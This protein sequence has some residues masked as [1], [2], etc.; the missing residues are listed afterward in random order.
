MPY[1][2]R[3]I[4]GPPLLLRG[5][6]A[7]QRLFQVLMMALCAS[8]AYGLPAAAC[9]GK[10]IVLD[11]RTIDY[12]TK[13]YDALLTPLLAKPDAEIA[14]I[15]ITFAS[16]KTHPDIADLQNAAL[17]YVT[18]KIALYGYDTALIN[19]QEVMLP[20]SFAGKDELYRLVIAY[21]PKM[22]AP[23]SASEPPC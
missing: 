8:L 18:S 19:R 13:P 1:H 3:P 16:T 21:G 12:K 11:I 10:S 4:F 2:G 5:R 9:A 6:F 15:D 20:R 14:R 23:M 7:L 22:A 17:K